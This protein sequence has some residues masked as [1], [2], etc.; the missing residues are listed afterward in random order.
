MKSTMKM[1]ITAMVVGVIVPG[2]LFHLSSRKSNT[3]PDATEGSE[4]ETTQQEQKFSLPVLM[5]DGNVVSME[6]DEY[7]VAVVL[8]EMPAEFE[9]ESLKA[10]AVIARTYALRRHEAGDKHQGAAVCTDSS[11]CQG[12][13][14]PEEYLS[15][16]GLE[17]AIEKVTTAVYA[18]TD[19][20][21]CYDGKIIE[22]T[23]FSCSGGYT[24]DAV[25]VWGADIPYLRAKVSPGEESATHF[26][27]TVTFSVKEFGELLDIDSAVDSGK[28][29][30]SVTYTNG[31][32]VNTMRICGKDYTGVELRKILGLRSTAFVISVVGDSVTITTKGFGHR[33]G[34]S[35]YGAEA[36]AVNGDNYETILSYYYQ[37][38]ELEDYPLL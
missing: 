3:V 10:Q 22:A 5:S 36:M 26:T 11:C 8:H 27:D 25:S 18:T 24:E 23:Y 16:G 1:I 2:I 9:L 28:W 15:S 32:G 17:K 7:V 37:G 33:V 30:E 20:V 31:G 21:L 34:L 29:V 4:I 14:L 12:F 13:C 6:L 38:T 19:Q 35:Q